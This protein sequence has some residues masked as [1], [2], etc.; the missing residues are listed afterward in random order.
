[1]KVVHIYCLTL[2]FFFHSFHKQLTHID[3]YR[4]GYVYV[5]AHASWLVYVVHA[6]VCVCVCVCMCI[7]IASE[8]CG[9]LSVPYELVQAPFLYHSVPLR[10][11][12]A[13]PLLAH[14]DGPV[15]LKDSFLV[16]LLLL[17]KPP[18]PRIATCS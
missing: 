17:P 16:I 8:V 10:A 9:A 13:F 7:S 3:R 4:H 12:S 11:L 2:F 1:M 15:F 18:A 6:F 5:C 14:T